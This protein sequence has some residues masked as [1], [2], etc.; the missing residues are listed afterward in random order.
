LIAGES[1]LAL[2][3]ALA[4]PRT[5]TFAVGAAAW[6]RLAEEHGLE[7]AEPGDRDADER[8]AQAAEQ[9]LKDLPW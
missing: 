3:T 8:I 7:E 2:Y 5:R 4:A 9:L 1:A 6:G